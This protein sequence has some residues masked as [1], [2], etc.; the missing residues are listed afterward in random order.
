MSFNLE[1]GKNSWRL[2]LNWKL[3]LVFSTGF[4]PLILL[5]SFSVHITQIFYERALRATI[6]NQRR[7]GGGEDIKNESTKLTL[8]SSTRY[9]ARVWNDV[10]EAR[11]LRLPQSA[12]RYSAVQAPQ[13][14][15][16]AQLASHSPRPLLNNKFLSKHWR[17]REGETQV[18][19]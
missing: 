7:G 14:P 9:S 17:G 4:W 19:F 11:Q 16:L 1:R 8:Y 12:L 13:A 3:Y 15:L 18:P 2:A 5:A 10:L 6:F